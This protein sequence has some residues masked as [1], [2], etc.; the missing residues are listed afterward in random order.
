M[1]PLRTQRSST[2]GVRLDP[3]SGGIAGVVL[4]R[5]VHA[6]TE[7]ANVR[8][9]RILV[10]TAS[11]PEA[12]IAQ[13]S[14][15][16]DGGEIDAAVI[17]GTF[18]DDP[19]IA[20]LSE[21]NLSFATFG[22]PWSLDEASMSMHRWVDVDGA[23]GTRAATEYALG[24]GNRI[25]FLG[26]HGR[27]GTGDDRERGWREAM[28]AAGASG[29]RLFSNEAVGEA[30]AAADAVIDDV[31]GIVCASDSLAM[32][33][34][35]VANRAGY[36]RLPIIGFDNTPTAAA[37]GISSVEQR[38]EDVASGILTLLMGSTGTRI[39]PVPVGDSDCNI[40]VTPQL[41]VR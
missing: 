8:G 25:A 24:F 39:D 28:H 15:L 11:S 18:H 2:I 20:W 5:F 16:V 7:R 13:I 10:Y 34:S 27:S 36:G 1:S 38:P 35:L 29:P 22:R 9:M 31:D 17:T 19:R 12:E 41:I 40:L 14:E 32:G 21:N 3:Y 23:T 4:D 30:A 6:L 33:A 37:L 26:W